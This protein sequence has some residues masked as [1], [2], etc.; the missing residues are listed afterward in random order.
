MFNKQFIAYVEAED[1]LLGVKSVDLIE[2]VVT[3]VDEEGETATFQLGEVELLQEV[4]EFDGVTV[5]NRDVF[6]RKDGKLIEMELQ[7]NG[8]VVFHV[9]DEEL[10]RVQSGTPV[11]PETQLK[12]IQDSNNATLVANIYELEIVRDTTFDFNAKIVKDFDGQYYNYFYALNNKSDKVINLVAVSFVGD[13]NVEGHEH[14]LHTVTHEEFVD[15]LESGSLAEVSTEEFG[16]FILGVLGTPDS[17]DSPVEDVEEVPY[18]D[19]CDRPEDN[20]QCE[21]W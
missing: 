16:N 5:F 20:C 12:R 18:C 15:A 21:P 17:N 8:Q 1:V 14:S 19:G 11:N 6:Q 13:V 2:Q 9:L 4:G 10:E 3:L 7:E